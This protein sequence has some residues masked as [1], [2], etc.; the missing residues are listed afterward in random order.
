MARLVLENVAKIFSGSRR[1]KIAA[2]RDLKLTIEDGELLVILGPSG[3]GKTT[4]LRLIAGLE[5]PDQG[6]I[7][8]DGRSLAGVPPKD[9]DVAMVLRTWLWG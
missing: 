9:R 7:F 6:G 5:T 4:T 8:L 3:C 1:E 2:V